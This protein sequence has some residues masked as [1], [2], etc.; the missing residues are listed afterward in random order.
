M[1]DDSLNIS[2]FVVLLFLIGEIIIDGLFRKKELI[3]LYIL[4]STGKWLHNY[5]MLDEI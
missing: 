1:I 2:N 5:M 4:F 3:D